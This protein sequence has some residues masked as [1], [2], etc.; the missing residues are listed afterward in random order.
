[1]VQMFHV[2]TFSA[3]FFEPV[4]RERWAVFYDIIASTAVLKAGMHVA[5]KN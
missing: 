5:T 2:W 1:M 4:A 3:F